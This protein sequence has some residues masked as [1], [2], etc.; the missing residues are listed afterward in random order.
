MR[1]GAVLVLLYFRYLLVALIGMC[2]WYFKV[3]CQLQINSVINSAA[4]W[5][6]LGNC[7]YCLRDK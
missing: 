1:G 4:G 5:L 2:V 3:K 7:Y 6:I